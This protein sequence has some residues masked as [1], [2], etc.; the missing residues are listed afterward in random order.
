M[1]LSV[2]VFTLILVL[3][4]STVV[5]AAS[6]TNGGFEADGFGGSGSCPESQP[7]GWTGGHLCGAGFFGAVPPEGNNFA[8]IGGGSDFPSGSLSQTI[9]S[10]LIGHSYMVTFF[11]GGENWTTST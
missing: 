11:L 9:G 8:I 5:S 1:R 2:G 4:L 3:T 6:I 10:L 7:T